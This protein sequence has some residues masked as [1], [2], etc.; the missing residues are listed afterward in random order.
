MMKVVKKAAAVPEQEQHAKLP[1]VRPLH[2][3]EEMDRMFEQLFPRGWMLPFAWERPLLAEMGLKLEGKMPRIDVVDRD[4][5]ILVRAEAPGV[6]KEELEVAITGNSVTIKGQTGHE[7]KEEKGEYYRCEISRGAF[8]R[9]VSL[10]AEVDAD[11]AA[12]E[13]KDGVLEIRLPKLEH[14]KRRVLKVV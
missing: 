5:E 13:F 7:E 14:A 9:T 6:K 3:I 10:P 4:A 1:A 11:K 8:S 2:P 12:A